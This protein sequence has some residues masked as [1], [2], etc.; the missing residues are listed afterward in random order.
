MLLAKNSNMAFPL[1]N[2]ILSL[3]VSIHLVIIASYKQQ[4][5]NVQPNVI[6]F[7][8]DDLGWDDVGYH[9]SQVL[10]PNI[11][12][13]ISKGIELNQYYTQ[14]VCTPSRATI[15]TGRYPIH[16]G[17]VG[18]I[19]RNDPFGL[20]L[21]TFTLADILTNYT[22]YDTLAVGKWHLGFYKW[23]YTPTFRGFEQFYG[24]YTGGEDYFTHNS[25]GYF[26]FRE[27]IGYQC[28]AKCSR[29]ANETLNIYSV[30][31][32]TDYVINNILPNYSN[33]NNNNNNNNNKNTQKK[34][35]N[36]PFFLYLAYQSVHSPSDVPIYYENMYNT[37]INNVKRRKFAGMVTCMDQSIGNITQALTQH[38]L[39]NN[40]IIIWVSDNGGPTDTSDSIGSR[41]YPLRGGKHSIWEG[42]TRVVGSVFVPNNLITKYA[43]QQQ[44]R[45]QLS[46]AYDVFEGININIGNRNS[47]NS[48]GGVMYNNLMHSVDWLPTILDAIGVDINDINLNYSIDGVSHWNAF[49]QSLMYSNNNINNV[50]NRKIEIDVPRTTIYYG[51]NVP[52]GYAWAGNNTG[53]RWKDYKLLNVTGGKPSD[54][55]KPVNESFEFDSSSS[56]ELIQDILTDIT[57]PFSYMNENYSL[58]NLSNDPNEYYD[59]ASQYPQLTIKLVE[60]M[61]QI[62]NTSVAQVEPDPD[63]TSTDIPHPNVTG[64]GPVWAPWC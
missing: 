30:T 7:L 6:F 19:A 43:K 40:T 52:N 10:T 17:L 38:G 42:G 51:H 4:T 16:T 31:L 28:G 5:S 3:I 54:W 27:D 53:L 56:Q 64:V 49:M 50:N 22:N 62:E 59:I 23:E 55:D 34:Q 12:N 25:A 46:D 11:D 14:C 32:F 39:D 26:D 21:S 45:K 47:N 24:Y 44:K 8:S 20:P 63:C 58:Y 61:I 57:L 29:V 15:L 13:L 60:M 1:V 37:T 18:L 33:T 35:K 48:G 9:T 41:N 36:N 2:Q